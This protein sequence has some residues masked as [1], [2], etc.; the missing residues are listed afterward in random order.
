MKTS[1]ISILI[2]SMFMQCIIAQNN[3]VI[4][5]GNIKTGGSNNRFIFGSIPDPHIGD[6]AA[7]DRTEVLDYKKIL[8]AE[9]QKAECE[10]VLIPG[11]WAG[12]HWEQEE[13]VKT[14][15]KDP[16]KR[17]F[18]ITDKIYPHMKHFLKG[19]GLK[20]IACPGDHEYGDNP[21]PVNSVRAKEFPYYREA[22]ANAFNKDENGHT[23]YN[24]NIGS[25]PQRPLGTQ[26]ENTSYAM[27][28]K[29]VMFV[30][31]DVFRYE[32]QQKKLGKEGVISSELSDDQA[33]W[34]DNV[35]TAGH[36][37]K[38]IEFIVVQSHFPIKLPI[39]QNRSSGMTIERYE[40][41]NLWNLLTKHKVDVY[42]AGE[43]HASTVS[44]DAKSQLVQF[45]HG[46]NTFG[47][48]TATKNKLNIKLKDSD[49]KSL[50][51]LGELTID[52]TSGKKMITS[53]GAMTPIMQNDLLAHYSFDELT[54]DTKVKNTGKGYVQQMMGNQHNIKSSEGILGNSAVFQSFDS[55]HIYTNNKEV[56]A[57]GGV[58]R[59]ISLWV[60]TKTS[61]ATLI[62]FG[63]SPT[64]GMNIFL[65]NGSIVVG[66]K[67]NGSV[68]AIKDRIDDGNW[69]FIVATYLGDSIP[70]SE[71]RLF[72]DGIEKETTKSKSNA[73]LNLKQMKVSLGV[74]RVV[75]DNFDYYFK[76]ANLDPIP[77]INYSDFYT[78][79]MDDFG[80]WNGALTSTYIKILFNA[81]MNNDL[82]YNATQVNDLFR[83]YNSKIPLDLNGKTW[84]WSKCPSGKAGDI[85]K[86]NNNYFILFD[87]NG[88]GLVCKE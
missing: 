53:S 68:R 71:T 19:Y 74:S 31:L 3:D 81:A 21:W 55:S 34:L 32:N 33:L 51:I 6:G 13:W 48:W 86:K 45:V 12:G 5:A 18:S 77:T 52:K 50:S 67:E 24:G 11:D 17:I 56:I 4:N 63:T 40:N 82:K 16:Q 27:I 7:W 54:Q 75:I 47:I 78:G 44:Q 28:H 66:S 39:F 69:H 38:E 84:K 72:V 80:I 65:E 30:S 29:N 79:L 83:V 85:I 9:M 64:S 46:S 76:K 1:Y 25:I 87:D 10:Y 88:T 20:V 36:A 57:L 14:F 62:M 35:L 73:S 8:F 61:D 2:F 42:I 49:D 23:L 60:K 41:S 15:G 26:Y 59:S 22:F 43:V 37:L 58:P 70:L